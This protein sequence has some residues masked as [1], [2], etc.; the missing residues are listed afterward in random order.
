MTMSRD[1]RIEE[2]LELHNL[3]QSRLA[4]RMDTQVTQIHRL[5][6]GHRRLTLDWMRN[7]AGAI[8][9]SVVASDLLLP[10]DFRNRLAPDEARLVDGY[11]TLRLEDQ[12][13]MVRISDVMVGQD[14]D[15]GLFRGRG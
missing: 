11:R 9:D 15:E 13:R 7:I 12:V 3:N 1:H 14:F 8:G 2:L 10:S 5:I 6:H 4:E